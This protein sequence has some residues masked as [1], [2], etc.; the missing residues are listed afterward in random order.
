MLI[1][2][3]P[4][5]DVVK[6]IGEAKK[7]QHIQLLPRA[8]LRMSKTWASFIFEPFLQCYRT[9]LLRWIYLSFTQTLTYFFL[10]LNELQRTTWSQCETRIDLNSSQKEKCSHWFLKW[11]LV[12]CFCTFQPNRQ[13]EN[14]VCLW[15]LFVIQVM[16]WLSQRELVLV[17]L[18][19]AASLFSML[20]QNV[21]IPLRCVFCSDYVS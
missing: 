2:R 17:L 6:D 11:H 16:S 7:I 3:R 15:I 18:L 12:L 5:G 19:I 14:T 10:K 21:E 13:A 1:D 9:I 4:A 20:P 8:R